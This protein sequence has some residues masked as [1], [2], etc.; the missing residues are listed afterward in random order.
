[1]YVRIFAFITG[2]KPYYFHMVNYF[3]G[4]FFYVLLTAHL[5]IILDNDQRDTHL[6]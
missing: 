6:I 1:M 5:N 3:F 4:L 2:M